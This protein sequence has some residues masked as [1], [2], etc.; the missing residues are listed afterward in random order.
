MDGAVD[1]QPTDDSPVTEWTFEV[2]V[3]TDTHEHAQQVMAER[4]DFDEWY[5][6]DYRIWQKE[7]QGKPSHSESAKGITRMYAA[8][9]AVEAIVGILETGAAKIQSVDEGDGGYMD[10]SLT[11]RV[12][13]GDDRIKPTTYGGTEE[14]PTCILAGAE[15]ENPDDCTTHEHEA[16]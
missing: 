4:V 13:G 5:G 10:V 16:S 2:V 14:P 1:P 8:E 6:F 7:P 9:H 15:G 3:E 12:M 11:V